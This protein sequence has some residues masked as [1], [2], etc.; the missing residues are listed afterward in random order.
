MRLQLSRSRL[1][2][3]LVL[4]IAAASARPARATNTA[5]AAVRT[6]MFD[7]P[8]S[9]NTG[10]RVYHPQVDVSATVAST[11]AIAA[12]Y[13]ADVV[14]GATPATFDAVSAATKF[15]DTR[16]LGHVSAG[17][18]RADGGIAFSFAY[19][20]ESDYRSTVFSATTHHDL[21]EHNFT[22]AL[23]Y[24]HNWDRV[25]DAD[26]TA[27]AGQVLYLVALPSSAGCFTNTPGIVTQKLNIDTLEPSLS[28]TMTPRLVIQGG[29]TIQILDGFQANPYRKVLVGSQGHTPQ[30]HLPNFRQRYALFFRLAYAFPELRAS[31]LA[32]LRGYEDSWAVRAITADVTGTKY[33][34]QFLLVS[35]RAHWHEQGGASF[36]RDAEGYRILGPAGQYWTGDRELSPMGNY[37]FGGK[38]A[39]FRRPQQERSSWFVEMELGGKY[40]F[41]LYRPQSE[42]APNADR[43]FAHIVQGAFAM[44]F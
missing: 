21:Y 18:D 15:S 26:N 19:G 30:E 25:C 10:V 27:A 1:I 5:E 37:L 40:E 9:K 33:I 3:G 20:T 23:A 11:L 13:S 8:S 29:A 36:Y 4:A 28:W 22:L 24:S 6:T 34:G 39:F 42:F 43:K 12:G 38:I 17:F 16:H 7:E 2:A 41:L 44:R 31:A 35:G 14:T 32:M